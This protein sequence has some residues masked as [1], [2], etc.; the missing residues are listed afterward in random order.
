MFAAE[1]APIGTRGHRT[2]GFGGHHNVITRRHLIE[3][4]A[5]DFFAE[6]HGV[7]VRCVKKIDARLKRQRKVCSGLI[8][9]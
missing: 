1:P 5:S 6:T 4:T 3:P 2:V 8:Q 9:A 7:Y